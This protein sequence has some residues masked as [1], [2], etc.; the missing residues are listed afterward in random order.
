MFF[1]EPSALH[2][3]GFSS[4]EIFV[5]TIAKSMPGKTKIGALCILKA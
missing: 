1:F 2:T 4:Q 3:S 5:K